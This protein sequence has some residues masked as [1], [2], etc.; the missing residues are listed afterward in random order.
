M[1]VALT[2]GMIISGAYVGD[3]FSPLSDTTN[4]AAAVSETGLFDHVTAMVSTTAP[5]FVIALV[6]YTIIGFGYSTTG[7]DNTVALELQQALAGGYNL[8]PVLLLPIVVVVVVCGL[9]CPL[10]GCFPGNH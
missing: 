8:N 6:L 7:Y 1:P 2:A 9:R 4:L 5:T 3:K 10:W